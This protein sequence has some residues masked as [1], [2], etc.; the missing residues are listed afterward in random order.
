MIIMLE[1]IEEL[2][3]EIEEFQNNVAASGE[4]ILALKQMTEQIKSQSSEFDV[5]SKAL[6]SRMD[7]IPS[8][9]EKIVTANNESI[10][11]DVSVELE[12]SIKQF[13]YEQSKYITT[14]Q[15]TQKIVDEY[16]ITAKEQGKLLT[17]N[18][19][20]MAEK[21]SSDIKHLLENITEKNE[22]LQNHIQATVSSELERNVQQLSEEQMK[23]LQSLQETKDAI[24]ECMAAIKLH[25]N[26]IQESI[27]QCENKLENKYNEFLQVLD[28]LN[29]SNLY[30]QNKQI[31]DEVTKKTTILMV[32]TAVSI[33]VGIVGLFM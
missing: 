30:E 27:S 31:K 17:E 4:M 2:E 21:I 22:E 15:D 3:K 16:T 23:Y 19:V 28:K 11:S 20:N 7:N 29:I 25:E 9:V 24:Q 18:T 33:V 14:L 10:K 12:K 13:A 1:T 26:K 5:Q 32:I 8:S 6:I